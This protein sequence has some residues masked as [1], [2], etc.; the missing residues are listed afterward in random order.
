MDKKILA[1]K[2]DMD[3]KMNHLVALDKPRDKKMKKCDKVMKKRKG[4]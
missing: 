1:A 3:K 4:K 2:R